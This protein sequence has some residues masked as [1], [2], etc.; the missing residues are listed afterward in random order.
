MTAC[1]S[2]TIPCS[3]C[4]WRR[5][6]TVG[7]SDIPG[8]DITLMRKLRACSGRGD[9]FRR[10]MACHG[11]DEGNDRPCVGYLA[12]EGWS[13]L[14]V[15]IMAMQG[16]IDVIA[17]ADDCADLDLWSSFDEMLDAYEEAQT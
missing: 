8:F 2:R 16:R 9:D 4:P 7:G 3:T 17:I 15:R 11:S 6:S 14:N 1:S 10:M 5:T 12:V 13:N